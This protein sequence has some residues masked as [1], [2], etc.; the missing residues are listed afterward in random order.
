MR[1]KSDNG[2]AFAKIMSLNGVHKLPYRCTIYTDGCGSMAHVALVA[3]RM[4]INHQ[5]LPPHE[6]SL[7]EAEKVCDR[8]WAAARTLLL[9]TNQDERLMYRA[10]DYACTVN[11]R[12][13]TTA[14]RGFRTPYEM[15]TGEVPSLTALRPFNTETAVTVPKSKR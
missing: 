3:A 2:K 4:G 14:S 7:N 15:I 9:H 1:L 11:L 6:P 10:V 12:M 8:M 5:F 13:A